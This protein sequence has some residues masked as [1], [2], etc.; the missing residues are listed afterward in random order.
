MSTYI[1]LKN[2][3]EKVR[4]ELHSMQVAKADGSCEEYEE[5][6]KTHTRRLSQND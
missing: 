1:E 6:K 2:K 5:A 3:L 4:S